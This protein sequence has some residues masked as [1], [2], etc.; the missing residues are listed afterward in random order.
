LNGGKGGNGGNGGNGGTITKSC[1]DGR[2]GRGFNGGDSGRVGSGGQGGKLILLLSNNDA[3]RAIRFKQTNGLK[4]A[5]GTPGLAGK[6]IRKC[7]V[8]NISTTTGN[9]GK[10]PMSFITN[11][12]RI[13]DVNFISFPDP[14]PTPSAIVSDLPIKLKPGA[15]IG[16]VNDKLSA[17]LTASGYDNVRYYCVDEG[18][19]VVTGIEHVN[20]K[21]VP[22][23]ES[24]RFSEE[25][26][27]FNKEFTLENLISAMF[28]SNKSYSR[29]I[30]FMVTNKIHNP[31][32]ELLTRKEAISWFRS[33]LTDLPDST[34]ALP[35][36]N[37]HKVSALIYEFSKNANGT[38]VIFSTRA[39]IP[40]N[41]HLYGA[42]LLPRLTDN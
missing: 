28:M 37:E 8:S 1:K 15:T 40:V 10:V 19:A 24:D 13:D 16:D 4:G 27:L 39:L 2:Q 5:Q 32:P 31:S 36:T 11:S 30:V 9:P 33:S 29:I 6:I 41:D 17:A 3:D 7:G 25:E 38:G 21:G 14:H 20:S 23:P 35:Y 34:A 18:F 22:L 12:G 42:R 26:A